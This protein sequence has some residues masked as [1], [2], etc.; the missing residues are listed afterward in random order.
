MR[1]Q[2]LLPALLGAIGIIALAVMGLP[3][4]IPH[5]LAE[6]GST[7]SYWVGVGIDATLWH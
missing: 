7:V 1:A 5:I 6:W 4:T 2:E 3:S